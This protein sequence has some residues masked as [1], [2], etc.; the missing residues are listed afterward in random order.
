MVFCSCRVYFCLYL[1]EIRAFDFITLDFTISFDVRLLST[2]HLCAINNCLSNIISKHTQEQACFSTGEKCF[3]T[4]EK[5]FSSLETRV[6]TGL[7]G[8]ENIKSSI[9][10]LK[11]LQEKRKVVVFCKVSFK[12]L[13]MSYSRIN[14]PAV[15]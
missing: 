15:K 12:F 14:C 6:N 3:S 2:I 11:L 7:R 1:A 9:Y 10:L 5:C 4:G 13:S 8:T